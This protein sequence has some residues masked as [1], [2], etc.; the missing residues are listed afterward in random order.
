MFSGLLEAMTNR[1]S[2]WNREFSPTSVWGYYWARDTP[3]TAPGVLESVAES[4]SEGVLWTPISVFWP[5]SSSK[6]VFWNL[7]FTQFFRIYLKNLRFPFLV[8]TWV[9][10]II[11][12]IVLSGTDM[13]FICFGTCVA[14]MMF[15]ILNPSLWSI[16]CSLCDLSCY[17]HICIFYF[18][19][20]PHFSFSVINVIWKMLSVWCP[21]LIWRKIHFCCWPIFTNWQERKKHKIF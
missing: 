21:I 6:K 14:T 3:A 12:D 5:W 1:D 9:Q 19:S 15:T 2:P 8:C 16:W 10:C 17:L 7:L 11:W 18:F 4:P 20:S 13:S